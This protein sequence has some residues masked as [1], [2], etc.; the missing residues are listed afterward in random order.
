MNDYTADD[1]IS[2]DITLDKIIGVSHTASNVWSRNEK[3]PRNCEGIMYF[4][5]GSIEYEFGDCVFRSYPG[6]V[7]KLPTGTPYRGKR[8]NGDPIEIYLVDFACIGSNFDMFPIPYSFSP[9][10]PESTLKE[11]KEILHIYEKRSICSYL[12]CKAAVTKLLC[13]LARDVA[14]NKCRYGEE[15][16]IMQMC[17]YIRRECVSVDFRVSDVSDHFHISDA[18]LRRLFAS[19]IHMSPVSYLT[20]A[21]VELAKSKLISNGEMSIGEIAYA[22][23]FSSVYYFS[24][25]FKRVV[26]CT[27][28]K[29][30]EKSAG[31]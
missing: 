8:L 3:I 2:A 16:R 13:S 4:V 11:F 10:D 19:E 15:S 12:E 14:V 6:C 1:F 9:S 23:G 17:E 26:G 30:R 5:S 25:T 20:T 29:Y 28:S 27:P 24:S 31:F 7:L 21:R 22:C 18:H